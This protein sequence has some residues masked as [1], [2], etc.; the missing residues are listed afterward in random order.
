MMIQFHKISLVLTV[1]LTNNKKKLTK[2]TNNLEG[3]SSSETNNKES[4]QPTEKANDS[5]EKDNLVN[6]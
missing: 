2:N 1:K 6:P 5:D 3:I 4:L